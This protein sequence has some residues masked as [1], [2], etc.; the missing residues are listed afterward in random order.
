MATI[1]SI[2]RQENYKVEIR[3][4]SG[5]VLIADEPETLGGK[6]LGFSPDELLAASLASCTSANLKM[7]AER[8]AWDLQ[9]VKTEITLEFLKAENKTVIDRKLVFVGNLGA[10]QQQ[11]LLSIANACPVHKMLSH[12][13]EIRSEVKEN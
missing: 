8:K 4:A 12:S 11:R 2:I 5:N 13:I 9:E 7:Y 1:T 10:A 6:D 3:S